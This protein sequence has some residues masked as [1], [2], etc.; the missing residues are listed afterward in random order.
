MAFEKLSSFEKILKVVVIENSK[1]VWIYE[2]EES[3]TRFNVKMIKSKLGRFNALFKGKHELIFEAG[4]KGIITVAICESYTGSQSI[5]VILYKGLPFETSKVVHKNVFYVNFSEITDS[6]PAKNQASLKKCQNIPKVKLDLRRIV[7]GGVQKLKGTRDCLE[8][9]KT[10]ESFTCV[11]GQQRDFLKDLVVVGQFD[12]KTIIAKRATLNFEEIWMFDQHACA[13]R[14]NLENLMM[15]STKGE[16]TRDEMNTKA[17]RSAIKFGDEL[18][19]RQ[20]E[21]IL[22]RL[23]KCHEPFHCAH[24]RP[25]C[26]LL[27]KIKK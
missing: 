20:Q 16:L 21:E 19:R 12:K 8:S 11:T 15:K 24:G 22:I 18:N 4:G 14:I 23:E 5:P 25:T 7:K 27:A 10:V 9:F 17:C 13:E 26:W 3:K 1:I 2:C 6:F